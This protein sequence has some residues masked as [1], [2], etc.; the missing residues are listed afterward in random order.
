MSLAHLTEEKKCDGFKLYIKT[1][2]VVY[3]VV[4]EE[5]KGC[6]RSSY[7]PAYLEMLGKC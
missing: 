6:C 1:T 2:L 5:R 7:Y 4:L 3:F